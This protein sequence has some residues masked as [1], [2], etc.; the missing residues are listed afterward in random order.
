MVAITSISVFE[1]SFM[2]K[3]VS[4]P[5]L[6]RTIANSQ[7]RLNA[8]LSANAEQTEINRI[9][10]AA[11]AMEKRGSFSDKTHA[12][13]KRKELEKH[14]SLR[15]FISKH[16]TALAWGAGF[17]FLVGAIMAAK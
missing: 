3:N 2:H 11:N 17:L 12:R 15:P 16:K 7:K 4:I 1:S 8:N 10:G 14:F 13:T 5:T 6:K 9:Q